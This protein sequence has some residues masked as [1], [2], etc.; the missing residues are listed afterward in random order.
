ML[1]GRLRGYPGVGGSCI[2]VPSLLPV[3]FTFSM[4]VPFAALARLRLK[5]FGRNPSR[6]IEH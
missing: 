3:R 1:R 5:H 4:L 2:V 6:M